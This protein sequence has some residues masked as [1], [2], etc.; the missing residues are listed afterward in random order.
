MCSLWLDE[1]SLAKGDVQSEGLAKLR[2]EELML[3]LCAGRRDALTLLY[4]RYRKL[5]FDVAARIETPS[6]RGLRYTR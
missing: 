1:M 6:S 5:V 3:K 2:D 4:D